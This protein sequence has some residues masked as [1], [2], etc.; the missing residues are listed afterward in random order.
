MRE[1]GFESAFSFK[2]SPRPGTPAAERDDGVP[3]PV[4][5]ARLAELQALLDEQRYAYQRAAVGQVFDVLVEKAGRLPG[6]L[7][8][9]TPHLLA[10]QFDAPLH[11]IGSIVPV[12]IV[13]A[14][15]NSL[16]GQLASEAV[17]A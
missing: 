10:V 11:H 9:K 4:M 8:G 3:E 15:T 2:Y 1:I 17:A 6:Q 7:A 16:F 12:R 13:R 14:G 5:A